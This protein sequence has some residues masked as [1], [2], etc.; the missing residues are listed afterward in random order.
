L[1]RDSSPRQRRLAEEL[2][3]LSLNP[4]LQR[5][6]TLTSQSTLPVNHLVSIPYADS[7]RLAALG[8]AQQQLLANDRLL[9]LPFSAE[10]MEAVLPSIE[11][12]VYGVITGVLSPRQGAE[13]LLQLE[14]R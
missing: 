13:A 9:R 2:A 6:I 4:M 11:E 7:G 1:G 12:L 14:G 3:L 10:R 5:Q 8:Q